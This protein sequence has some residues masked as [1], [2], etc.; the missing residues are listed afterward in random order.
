MKNNLITMKNSGK[1]LLGFIILFAAGAALGTLFAPDKGKRTRRKIVKK[2]K[3]LFNSFSNSLADGKEN[4]EEIRDVL[5]DNLEQVSNK[6]QRFP[7][8]INS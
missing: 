8:K 1:I 6:I 5:K 4:L 3:G 7:N 2:G